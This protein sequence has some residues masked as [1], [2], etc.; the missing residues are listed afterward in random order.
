MTGAPGPPECL[1]PGIGSRCC[2]SGPESS[3]RLHLLVTQ[4]CPQGYCETS[5]R[6]EDLL[7][8]AGMSHLS[9]KCKSQQLLHVLFFSYE[10]IAEK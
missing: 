1:V 7:N 6:S 8:V 9:A 4:C 5:V 3:R 2:D 10:F